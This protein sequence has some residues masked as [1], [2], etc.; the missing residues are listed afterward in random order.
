MGKNK[1]KHDHEEHHKHHDRQHGNP[2]AQQQQAPADA[3]ANLQV[4]PDQETGNW[5]VHPITRNNQEPAKWIV[6][7]DSKNDA[8]NLKNSIANGKAKPPTEDPQHYSTPRRH[9]NGKT[10][11]YYPKAS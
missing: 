9:S 4:E 6:Q 8:N 5:N 1:H 2:Q 11:I 3:G 10:L 7:C